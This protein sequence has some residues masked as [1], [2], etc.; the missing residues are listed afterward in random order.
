MKSRLRN[1]PC[2]GH[3]D[4]LVSAPR[5]NRVRLALRRL[6][7]VIRINL[8]GL[9]HL[10]LLIE[11]DSW[12]VIDG[13]LGDHPVLAISDFQTQQRHGPH[14]DMPARVT[15]YQVHAAT[16]LER[17]LTAMDNILD[18]RLATRQPRATT[19][20][21]IRFPSPSNPRA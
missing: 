2:L 3:R 4:M 6:E 21:L 17:V 19:G 14:E 7:P 11:P 5:Y 10:R 15:F 12:I 18:L 20:C 8:P 9:R 16:I 1:T 13:S